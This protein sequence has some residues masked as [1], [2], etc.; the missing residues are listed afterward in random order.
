M[1]HVDVSTIE[2][3]GMG[4]DLDRRGL[5]DALGTTDLAANY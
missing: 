5:T 4:E 1:E 3:D 2:P